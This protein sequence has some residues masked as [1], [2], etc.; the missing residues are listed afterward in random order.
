MPI[1]EQAFRIYY[2]SMTDAEVLAVAKNRKSFIPVAQNVLDEEL[3]RRQLTLPTDSPAETPSPGVFAQL[4]RIL[5]RKT[6]G[7]HPGG[8]TASKSV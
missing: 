2:A 7:A 8:T 4:G 3:K 6:A 1:Q 5:R